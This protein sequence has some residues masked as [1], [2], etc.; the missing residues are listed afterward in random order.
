MG[1]KNRKRYSGTSPAKANNMWSMLAIQLRLKTPGV[2]IP[3][4]LHRHNKAIGGGVPTSGRTT[5]DFMQVF[6]KLAAVSDE[7]ITCIVIVCFPE[8]NSR[9]DIGRPDYFAD[10]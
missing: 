1:L 8:A 6:R 2:E 5:R 7:P 10:P 9:T 3:R 4:A